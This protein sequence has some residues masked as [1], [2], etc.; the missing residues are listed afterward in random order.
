[1]CYD[2][3]LSLAGLEKLSARREALVRRVFADI[4]CKTNVLN[5][6]LVERPTDERLAAIRDAYPY[7]L[8]IFKTKRALKS[9]IWYCISRRW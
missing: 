8:P 3:A 5:H 1:M 9:L 6:L 2:D 4:K 7:V